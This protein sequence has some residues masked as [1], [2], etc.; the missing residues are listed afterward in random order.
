[1]L[2]PLTCVEMLCQY[3]GAK[4]SVILKGE[5]IV[6]KEGSKFVC[7]GIVQ[8]GIVREY[9]YPEEGSFCDGVELECKPLKEM[10]KW[11]GNGAKYP[12]LNNILI[13]VEEDTVRLIGSR[14]GIEFKEI[15]VERKNII[16]K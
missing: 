4:K 8:K 7:K 9:P 14:D 1:M 5:W 2:I 11:I 12:I 6:S 15:K 16:L 13:I 10:M 3:T